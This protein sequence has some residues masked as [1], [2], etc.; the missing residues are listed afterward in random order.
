MFQGYLDIF[1]PVNGLTP[2]F[3]NI[4]ATIEINN[5]RIEQQ[6]KYKFVCK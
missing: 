4:D 2:P 1:S 5:N 3:A 6:W